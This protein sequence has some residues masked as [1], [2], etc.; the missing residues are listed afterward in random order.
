MADTSQSDMVTGI[1]FQMSDLESMVTFMI[2]YT[3]EMAAEIGSFRSYIM[4]IVG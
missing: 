4:Q 2:M 3:R 1:F